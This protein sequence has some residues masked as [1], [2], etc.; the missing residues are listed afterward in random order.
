MSSWKEQPHKDNFLVS[1]CQCLPVYSLGKWKLMTKLERCMCLTVVFVSNCQILFIC[2]KLTMMFKLLG[3]R[4]INKSY[5]G[6][7]I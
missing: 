4:D 5:T 7:E 2:K 1:T 6:F 3:A